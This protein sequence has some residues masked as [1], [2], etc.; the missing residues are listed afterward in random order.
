ML[1][2]CLP[3]LLR[4]VQ[5]FQAFAERELDSD[6]DG[7]VTER[8]V[9]AFLE[10]VWGGQQEAKGFS[11]VVKA[12]LSGH[13]RPRTLDD[14]HRGLGRRRTRPRQ[15]ASKQGDSWEG[16]VPRAGEEKLRQAAL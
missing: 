2:Y 3:V 4:C 7:Q 11:R 15:I 8:D 5:S 10:A 9:Y 13:S 16:R 1:A 6:G 12:S 14:V